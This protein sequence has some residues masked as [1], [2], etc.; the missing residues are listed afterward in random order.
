MSK[1]AK[2]AGKL[3]GWAIAQPS[4]TGAP[5]LLEVVK[6]TDAGAWY[7]RPTA[8]AKPML[9]GD[10]V[11]RFTYTDRAAA[12]AALARYQAVY[13]TFGVVV[14]GLDA[15]QAARLEAEMHRRMSDQDQRERRLAP[16]EG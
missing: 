15:E 9:I 13:D 6:R 12:E 1:R 7:R 14:G 11:V 2:K 10:G 5:V 3:L 4:T 16:Q 8:A